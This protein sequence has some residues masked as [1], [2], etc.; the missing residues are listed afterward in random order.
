M[1]PP[2][3][4]T[5]SEHSLLSQVTFR[6]DASWIVPALGSIKF[7]KGILC[8]YTVWLRIHGSL[9]PL[10]QRNLATFC[11]IPRRSLPTC[12]RSSINLD[13]INP[14]LT[15]LSTPVDSVNLDLHRKRH[16][17]TVKGV[18]LRKVDHELA[19]LQCPIRWD[20]EY[21]SQSSPPAIT[22]PWI[23]RGH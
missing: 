4:P 14:R 19:I 20:I 15:V 3:T 7:I 16:E 6:H 5:S 12:R 8:S 2:P 23:M 1:N 11:T 22:A 17:N 9:R 10:R 13:H 21:R 18:S